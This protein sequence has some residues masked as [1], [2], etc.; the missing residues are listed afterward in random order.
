ME[1]MDLVVVP[2]DRKVIPNPLNPNFAAGVAK[3]FQ[4]A[5]GSPG[6]APS[7]AATDAI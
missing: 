6:G 1:D 7:R 3:G 4:V 2:T 5:D